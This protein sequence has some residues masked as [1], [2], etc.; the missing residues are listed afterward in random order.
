M[1]V[2]K[3]IKSTDLG[4]FAREENFLGKAPMSHDAIHIEG[5]HG[6]EI[7]ELGFE[8]FS[9]S[10][11]DVALLNN[12]QDEVLTWLNGKGQLEYLGKLTEIY[13]LDGYEIKRDS[14]TFSIP[15]V[16]SPFWYKKS[17]EFVEY[18]NTDKSIVNEGSYISQPLIKLTK[19]VEETVEME[20]NDVYFKYT[21]NGDAYS[22]I[23]CQE[24]NATFD[25]L[26][27]NRQLQIGFKFPILTPGINKLK[28]ISGDAKVEIKRKERWL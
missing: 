8:N 10:L 22:L 1:F 13:F 6:D 9:S 19:V 14:K 28:I 7:I 3:G 2:F 27:R 5:R 16:R 20:I 17:D 11:N 12:N 18:K 24:M 15:F 25:G 26:L 4:V 23:D 21:F